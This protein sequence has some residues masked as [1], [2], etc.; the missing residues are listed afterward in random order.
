MPSGVYERTEL[1]KIKAHFGNRKKD[2][3]LTKRRCLKCGSC[4]KS[5]GIHN[6]ICYSCYLTNR[7]IAI[8]ITPSP[9]FSCKRNGEMPWSRN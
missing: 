3:K 7:G 9:I 1:N 5:E 6:R 2:V 8:G 4:F